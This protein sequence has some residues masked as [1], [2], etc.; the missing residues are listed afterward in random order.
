MQKFANPT[1]FLKIANA[2]LPYI[3]GITIILFALGLY[4]A[5]ITSPADQKHGEAVRMMYVHVPA[6]WMGMFVYCAMAFFS[7]IAIIYRHPLAD[8][9]AKTAA[10]IGAVFCFLALVTGSLWGKPGWGTYW[11]WDARITSM[12]VL[13]LFYLGYIALWQSIEEPT[14]AAA[15]A[16]VVAIVGVINVVIVKFSVEWWHTLHQGAS[17]LKMGGSTI[18]RSMLWVLLVMAVAYTVLFLALHLTAIRSEIASRKLRQV[19]LIEIGNR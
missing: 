11:V 16:R 15:I 17:V 8:A 19:R 6:A 10:P 18:D 1:N 13:M 9:A 3:W 4:G 2:V 7:A 14:R 5:L 12:F